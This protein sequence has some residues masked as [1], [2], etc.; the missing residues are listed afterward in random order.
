MQHALPQSACFAVKGLHGSSVVLT[1]LRWQP[2]QP[3]VMNRLSEDPFG[4]RESWNDSD[5]FR[6]RVH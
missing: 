1:C 3:G 5:L 6:D 2:S 4:D